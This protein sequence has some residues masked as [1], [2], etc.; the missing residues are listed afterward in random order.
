M[1]FVALDVGPFLGSKDSRLK[2]SFTSIKFRPPSILPFDSRTA[3]ILFPPAGQITEA[4]SCISTHT[5]P[6]R[7]SQTPY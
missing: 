2:V 3:A 4:Q 6:L 1:S 7:L 5:N